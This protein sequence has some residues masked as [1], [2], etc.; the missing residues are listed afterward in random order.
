MNVMTQSPTRARWLFPEDPPGPVRYVQEPIGLRRQEARILGLPGRGV[1]RPR[2]LAI[3]GAGGDYTQLNPLLYGLQ[4]QGIASLAMNLSGHSE[5]GGGLAGQTSIGFNVQEALRFADRLRPALLALL[6]VDMGAMAALR[7]AQVHVQSVH[8]IVLIDPCLYAD[9]AIQRPLSMVLDSPP[10]R[11][12]QSDL[13][14]FLQGFLGHVM[15]VTGRSAPLLLPQRRVERVWTGTLADAIVRSLSPRRVSRVVL[16]DCQGPVLPWLRRH[17]EMA[18]S[19]A[20]TVAGFLEP[21]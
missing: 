5:A 10:L 1:A 7:V 6:A 12:E 11:W 20:G 18:A 9:D 19:L 17:P 2:L 8:R 21:I 4:S 13:L 16:D 14:G 3:H 15:V